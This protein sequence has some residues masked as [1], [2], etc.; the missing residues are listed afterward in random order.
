MVFAEIV[1]DEYV[2]IQTL[3]AAKAH[4]YAA[5]MAEERGRLMDNTAILNQILEVVL[6][7]KAGMERL[8]KRMDRLEERMDRLEERMDRLEERMDALE[9]RMDRLEERMDAIEAR[10][11]KLEERMDAIE[12]RMD[13]IEARMDAIETRMDAIE[14]RMDAIETRVDQLKTRVGALE[15]CV[16]T[17]ETRVNQVEDLL[18]RQQQELLGI[19]SILEMDMTSNISIIV[20]NHLNL[21]RKL[22]LV[23]H[24]FETNADFRLR[25]NYLD[26]EVRRIKSHLKLA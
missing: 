19:R 9:E 4:D 18:G 13:A 10:M 12:A 26:M 22:N 14:S 5:I 1:Y 25:V 24:Q 16:G 6:D 21:D 15:T 7:L 23:L 8:E 17:L 20:E 11:D 2:H 3:Q